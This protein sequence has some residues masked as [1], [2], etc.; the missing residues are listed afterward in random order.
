MKH[1]LK[2][3]G[4]SVKTLLTEYGIDSISQIDRTGSD[5]AK[6]IEITSK[7]YPQFGNQLSILSNSKTPVFQS[8]LQ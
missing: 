7:E 6:T 8:I 4:M 2:I 3:A 1:R 5:T